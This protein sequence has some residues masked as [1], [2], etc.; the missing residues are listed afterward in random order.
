MVT[1]GWK[2]KEIDCVGWEP[3]MN[4]WIGKEGETPKDFNLS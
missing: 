3:K 2:A 4:L 1:C